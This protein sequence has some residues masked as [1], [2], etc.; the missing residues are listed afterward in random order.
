MS[1]HYSVLYEECLNALPL[2]EGKLFL[3]GTLGGGGHSEGILARSGGKL[4]A[5]DKDHAAI[6]RCTKR[7]APYAGRFTL[8][9]NDFKNVKAVLEDLGIAGVDGALLDLGVSSFQLD[10]AERGFSYNKEA[11]LD[12]RMDKDAALDAYQVVNTYD[13]RDLTRILYQFGEEKFASRI[14]DRIVKN[15]PIETTVQLAEIVKEAIPA[16]ARRTGGHPAKRTFQAI[17]IEVNG[18]LDNL[19]ECVGDFIDCLNPGGVLAVISFHSL[20]DRAVKQAMRLAE[21]PCTCPPDFPQCVCGKL[22]K[23][24]VLTRK[25]IL[26]SEKELEENLRSRSA[27]LRIFKK[28]EE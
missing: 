9:R 18:E 4:I 25:P 27:K 7:L 26:P 8:V 15:R 23:G 13:K 16:A 28:I 5:I 6:E 2:S 19:A 21:N 22:P 17:R 12:M 24:K 10:E 1:G 14:A 20:E 3:D 11:P